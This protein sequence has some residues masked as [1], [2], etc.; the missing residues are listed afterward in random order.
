MDY[1]ELPRDYSDRKCI[2]NLMQNELE[3]GKN[4]IHTQRELELIKPRYN[5]KVD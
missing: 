1:G 2:L 4:L 3:S 5:I